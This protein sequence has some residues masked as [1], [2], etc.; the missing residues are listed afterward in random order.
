MLAAQKSRRSAPWL[1]VL[2]CEIAAATLFAAGRAGGLHGTMLL[3]TPL[4]LAILGCFIAVDRWSDRYKLRSSADAWIARGYDSARSRY[5]WRIEELTSRRERK[6][7]ARSLRSLSNHVAHPV[8]PSPVPI[9]VVALRPCLPFFEQLTERLEDVSR[10]VSA[11]G[12]LGVE[13]LLTDG[14]TSPLYGAPGDTRLVLTDLLDRLE[15]R[16]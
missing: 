14:A 9:D 3:V 11:S 2:T 12:V 6:A 5:A 15:V 1:P 8:G 7:L 16:R 4:S 10:P 13:R